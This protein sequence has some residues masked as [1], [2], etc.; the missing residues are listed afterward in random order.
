MIIQKN[1]NNTLDYTNYLSL[2]K[3]SNFLSPWCIIN[4]NL[5]IVEAHQKI[6]SFSKFDTVVGLHILQAFLSHILEEHLEQFLLTEERSNTIVV[7]IHE[8]QYHIE[9]SKIQNS[10]YIL[11]IFMKL[12]DSTLDKNEKTEEI[13]IQNIS[14][15]LRTPLTIILGYIEHITT[16]QTTDTFKEELYCIQQQGHR[17]HNIIDALTYLYFP[18][19]FQQQTPDTYENI[20]NIITEFLG[21]QI[22][23][24]KKSYISFI[25]CQKNTHININKVLLYIVLYNLID[26]AIKFSSNEPHIIITAKDKKDTIVVSIQD[27]GM[28]IPEHL[29]EKIFER[30]YRVTSTDHQTTQGSGLGLTITKKIIQTMNSSIQLQSAVHKGTTVIL[31]FPKDTHKNV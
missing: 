12:Q 16:N 23:K 22:T 7:P 25:Q 11:L 4:K 8:Q 6:T 1:N 19:H 20:N 29:H 14:H 9:I 21:T 17:L 2:L 3:A 13:F 24:K 28:G 31:T 5:T 15:E 30:F 18:K 10:P 27:Q 26:N